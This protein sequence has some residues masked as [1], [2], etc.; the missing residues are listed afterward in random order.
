MTP[1][2]I[3]RLCARCADD[4]KGEEIVALDLRGISSVADF[5]VIVT[6]QSEPH[7][8]AIRNEVELRLKGEGVPPRGIDGYPLS[9]WVVM[10]YSDVIVH[11]FLK[12]RR[13]FYSLERLWGDAPPLKW[14]DA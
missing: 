9:Q 11:I 10:D 4:K 2:Q 1:I 14:Q 8:K 12:D 7:L 6:G 3:A 13:E 5:F